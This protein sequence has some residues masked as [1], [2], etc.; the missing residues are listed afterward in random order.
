[1]K[2]SDELNQILKNINKGIW[3][4]RKARFV[5]AIRW[6]WAAIRF[7]FM[8]IWWFIRDRK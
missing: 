8:L 7:P 5:D 6:T 3:E 2:K 4:Y 1:M